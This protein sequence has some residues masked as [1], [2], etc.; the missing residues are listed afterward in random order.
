MRDAKKRKKAP[1]RSDWR[2]GSYSDRSNSLFLLRLM[3]ARKESIAA[4]RSMQKSACSNAV[5]VFLLWF[6][7]ARE[8]VDFFFHVLFAL[9]LWCCFLGLAWF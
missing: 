4:K 9:V 2:L 3:S 5:M 7:D 8:L 1:K 6:E